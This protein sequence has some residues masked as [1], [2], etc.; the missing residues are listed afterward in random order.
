M[1]MQPIANRMR[2]GAGRF[3]AT[4]NLFVVLLLVASPASA[5]CPAPAG[6]NEIVVENCLPGNPQS[7]WMITGSGD[8]AIQGFATD[9]SYNQGATAQFKIKTTATSYRI[10]IY[11]LGWYNGSGAR[12]V[13]TIPNTA[14]IKSNQVPCFGDESATNTTHIV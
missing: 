5:V 9:I 8:P 7:E 2:L 10:D 3:V 14:T 6:S 13:A 11:R 12:R 1:F 4:C